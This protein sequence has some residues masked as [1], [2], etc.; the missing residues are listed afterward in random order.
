MSFYLSRLPYNFQ[1][2][3]EHEDFLND[4]N[5]PR[6]IAD[7][8]PTFTVVQPKTLETVLVL[9][10]SGS[11]EDDNDFTRMEALGQVGLIV[12]LLVKFST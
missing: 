5:P 6:D 1:V 9:D 7:T 12:G 4:V 3:R 2:L 8:T 10:V 11:M